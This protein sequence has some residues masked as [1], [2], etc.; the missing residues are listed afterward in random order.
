MSTSS[1]RNKT[2]YCCVPV[3]SQC[4]KGLLNFLTIA[5]VLKTQISL[6]SD[7]LDVGRIF[8]I[9]CYQHAHGLG[10]LYTY[11]RTSRTG[12]GPRLRIGNQD[13]SFINFTGD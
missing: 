9:L 12:V 6:V 3:V 13:A 5:V 2:G 11:Q 8:L 7:T 1:H 10:L 4:R